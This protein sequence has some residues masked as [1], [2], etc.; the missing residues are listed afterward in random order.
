MP[1]EEAK[2]FAERLGG[3]L[4]EPGDQAE[5]MFLAGLIPGRYTITLGIERGQDGSW[6]TGR[7]QP[8]QYSQ[9]DGGTLAFQPDA[10]HWGYFPGTTDNQWFGFLEDDDTHGF[11]IEW[12]GD[13]P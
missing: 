10:H 8:L 3:Y 9:L 12:D 5:D 7:G 11:I 2:A 13:Q 6:Q 4:A 1:Y